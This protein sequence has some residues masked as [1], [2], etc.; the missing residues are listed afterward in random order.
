[1]KTPLKILSIALMVFGFMTSTSQAQ[2]LQ[3]NQDRPEVIAK[4][5]T[6]ELSDALNLSGD[7]QR[8]VFRAL[9]TRAAQMRKAGAATNT[10]SQNKTQT[11]FVA[12]MKGILSES[13]FRKWKNMPQ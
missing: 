10:D 11:D 2:A 3:Q 7:Q 8:A 5:Q 1:M 13:Q 12:T 6:A 4:T 9:V